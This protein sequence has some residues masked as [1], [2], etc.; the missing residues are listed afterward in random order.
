V[1]IA[2]NWY[3]DAEEFD[4]KK[5]LA[6]EFQKLGLQ[7]RVRGPLLIASA[8]REKCLLLE[9]ETCFTALTAFRILKDKRLARA[10]FKRA[11]VSFAEGKAFK[12]SDKESAREKVIEF[13]KAVVKPFDGNKGRGVSVNVTPATFDEAWNAALQSVTSHILVEKCF[14]GGSEARY[15]VVDS[16]CVAV[17]KRVPP[18]LIGNGIDTVSQLIAAK[19][20][21]RLNN[22]HLRDRP[23]IIDEYRK[24]ILNSQKL[25]LSSIPERGCKVTVDWKSNASTG[26]ETTEI[27]DIVHPSMKRIAERV[28]RTIQ[29][30]HVGGIDILANDHTSKATPSNYIVIEAN[31]RPDLGIHL[32]PMYGRPV[33]VS[34]IIA[35]S[36]VKHMGLGGA[37]PHAAKTHRRLEGIT[38]T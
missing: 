30:L 15:L 21:I 14:T 36:C 38:V 8:G 32:F 2:L 19:N 9:A 4:T 22:P 17:A 31:T 10:A 28:A 6:L 7:T 33:N 11:G 20:N 37:S 18:F 26:G 1:P 24:L 27:T 29:G 34:K 35:E 16:Q 13:G 3:E 5:L 12:L 25:D 23:I